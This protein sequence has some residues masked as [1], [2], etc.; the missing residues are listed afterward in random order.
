MK[1]Q[2]HI[3]GR[4]VLELTVPDRANA[5]SVQNRVSEIVRQK[6]NPA[7]DQIFSKISEN[8]HTLT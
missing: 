4:E 1:E 5:M 2:G 3:I 7:L 8:G 6:L